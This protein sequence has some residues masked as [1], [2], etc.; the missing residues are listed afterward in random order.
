MNPTDIR[1]RAAR[2][3]AYRANQYTFRVPPV[4]SG[5]WDEEAWCNFVTFKDPALNG[6]LPYNATAHKRAQIEAC[7]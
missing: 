7:K 4:Y 6:F 2:I 5:N 3:R 1:R